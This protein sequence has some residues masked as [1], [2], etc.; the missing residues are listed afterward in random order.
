M[1]VLC[2]PLRLALELPPHLVLL[3][4][5]TYACCSAL[6]ND[7][8]ATLLRVLHVKNPHRDQ[9][10]TVEMLDAWASCGKLLRPLV[11]KVVKENTPLATADHEGL[12]LTLQILGEITSVADPSSDEEILCLS[13]VDRGYLNAS[14]G[15][16]NQC[17]LSA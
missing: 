14:A 7:Q 13:V 1:R 10:A 6:L 4:A 2:G 17:V 15:R 11:D 5:H 12:L 16:W 9:E 3:L 8:Q